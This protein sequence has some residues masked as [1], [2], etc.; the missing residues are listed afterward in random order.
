MDV[1]SPIPPLKTGQLPQILVRL[2]DESE[3]AGWTEVKVNTGIW[4]LGVIWKTYYIAWVKSLSPDW[5]S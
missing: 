2:S 5:S 1:M 3:K 4:E